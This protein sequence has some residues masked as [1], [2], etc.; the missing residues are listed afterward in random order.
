MKLIP[1]LLLAVVCCCQSPAQVRLTGKLETLSWMEGRWNRTNVKEG[2]T[3]F[4]QW[5][6]VSPHELKGVGVTLRGTDTVFVESL[7]IVPEGDDITY[8]AE[9]PHNDRPVKFR[10]TTL[11]DRAFV[12]ENPD[13]DFPKKIAYTLEGEK[14]K[15]K[16]SGNGREM[17][18]EFVRKGMK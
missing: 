6:V 17:E 14:L 9:V 15:A 11:S 7:R 10:L 5:V 2:E 16:I 8:I 12:C 3:A 4:E 13:H 18:F 1:A